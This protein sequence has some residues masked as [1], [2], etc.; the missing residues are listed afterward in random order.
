MFA[1]SG[2]LLLL[3]LVPPLLIA[4][5]VYAPRFMIDQFGRE[6][7]FKRLRMCTKIGGFLVSTRVSVVCALV[8]LVDLCGIALP[9]VTSSA[10]EQVRT[11]TYDAIP[12]DEPILFRVRDVMLRIPAGYLA[13]WPRPAMRGKVNERKSID[14]NYWMPQRRYVEIEEASLAGFRPREKGRT[15]TCSGRVH[16]K[17]TGPAAA[18]A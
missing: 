3:L 12:L 18:K 14:F 11:M 7:S 2:R 10:A 4:T 13:P 9:V 6:R 5:A 17:S 15:S 8:L 16:G 1:W